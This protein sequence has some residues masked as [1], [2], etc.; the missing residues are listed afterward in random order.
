M[1]KPGE[2][3][4]ITGQTLSS[5]DRDPMKLF[6]YVTFNFKELGDKVIFCSG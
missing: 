3:E 2:R 4:T 6:E 5:S 1:R